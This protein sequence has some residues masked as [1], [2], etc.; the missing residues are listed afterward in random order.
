MPELPK[1]HDITGLVLCG[2]RARR[3]GGTEKPMLELPNGRR[4]IDVVIETLVPQVSTILL[5]CSDNADP[6]HQLG[7]AVVTDRRSDAGPLAGIEAGLRACI[8]PWC[9]VCPGDAPGVS[10]TLAPTLAAAA[11][12]ADIVI[13]HDGQRDQ[14]L[15]M[16]VKVNV[17]DSLTNVLDDGARAV[18][19]W[20]STANVARVAMDDA[21]QF[22]N[23]NTPSDLAAWKKR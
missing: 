21:A 23:I 13:P 14:H 18:G 6:Y 8:T 3:M 12:H 16:L 1:A 11:G 4:I 19:E 15:F 7:C 17:V 20:L 22:Y 2:G 9:L 10:V 5:S